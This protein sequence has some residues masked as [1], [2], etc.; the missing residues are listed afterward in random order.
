MSSISPEPHK[1]HP[2][3]YFV[4]DRSNQEELERLQ[5]FDSLFTAGMG[6]VLPEQPDP[7]A[8]PRVLDV[9]CAPGSGANSCRSTSACAAQGE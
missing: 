4:Q 1:E 8:F 5:V 9:G 6:G 2:S 3:T 7:T